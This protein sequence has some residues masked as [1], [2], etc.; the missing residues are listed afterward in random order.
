ML[1]KP[2]S[3]QMHGRKQAAIDIQIANVLT[4]CFLDK[5]GSRMTVS[6]LPRP[7]QKTAQNNGPTRTR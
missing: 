4:R 6:V 3:K 5:L 1:G 2:E 7:V